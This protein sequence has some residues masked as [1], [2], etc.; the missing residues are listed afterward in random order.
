M[1][2]QWF[3]RIVRAIDAS[4]EGAEVMYAGHPDVVRNVVL[5][6]DARDGD[7]IAAAVINEYGGV[8]EKDGGYRVKGK[9]VAAT[10]ADDWM[11]V[12]G[13][14]GCVSL[15]FDE[16][17]ET[18]YACAKDSGVEDYD[19]CPPVPSPGEFE[20]DGAGIDLEAI[21]ADRAVILKRSPAALADEAFGLDASAN[22]EEDY[23]AKWPEA[24]PGL[25]SGT[26]VAN[27][28]KYVSILGATPTFLSVFQGAAPNAWVFMDPEDET[29]IASANVGLM[30]SVKERE[31]GSFE[32]TNEAW[33]YTPGPEH[34]AGR[35]DWCNAF[36][37]RDD[38]VYMLS[39]SRADD[40][41]D[42]G[43]IAP[44]CPRMPELETLGQVATLIAEGGTPT[45]ELL[46]DQGAVSAV[47]L[48]R[49]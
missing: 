10:S 40:V 5:F 41:N 26:M 34:V 42:A 35:D 30:R 17:K 48:T 8:E 24:M 39:N 33:K 25:W 32:F 23:A 47:M 28:E 12:N 20:N 2:G 36:V 21:G 11:P 46:S 13:D 4:V 37:L 29:K 6:F 44:E 45:F 27:D 9:N 7:A 43:T 22:E 18:M 38:S 49:Q 31:D 15:A 3:G 1:N 14:V 16:K 19:D